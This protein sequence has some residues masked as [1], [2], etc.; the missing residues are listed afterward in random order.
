M[1]TMG[2]CHPAPNKLYSLENVF[3]LA[4]DARSYL[5]NY[6]FK[7]VDRTL[8]ATITI[9]QQPSHGILRLLTEA[10]RGVLFSDTAGPVDPSDPGYVYLP[11]NGYVGKDKVIAL[12]EIAGVKIKVIYY[13]LAIEGRVGNINHWCGKRGYDWKISATRDAESQSFVAVA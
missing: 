7:T 6:E 12:V 10:D 11:Q 8:P 3:D 5:S 2:V 4:A 13:L 1:R 9:Q